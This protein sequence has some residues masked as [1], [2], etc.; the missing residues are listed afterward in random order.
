MVV[1]SPVRVRRDRSSPSDRGRAIAGRHRR[2][3][4]DDDALHGVAADAPN[5]R[6]VISDPQA[7][8]NDRLAGGG[9]SSREVA[10]SIVLQLSDAGRSSG[11]VLSAV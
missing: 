5:G 6:V 7:N 11:G 10:S 8:R 9:R 4:T 1:G 2:S 3:S